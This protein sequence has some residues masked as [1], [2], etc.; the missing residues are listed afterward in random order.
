MAEVGKE[1]EAHLVG[2][3]E[4]L[5]DQDSWMLVGQVSEED[6]YRLENLQVVGGSGRLVIPWPQLRKETSQLPPQGSRQDLEQCPVHH[7]SPCR[8]DIDPGTERQD[9]LA[10]VAAANQHP[11][12]YFGD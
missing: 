1:P 5:K 2:P 12:I 11:T 10:L 4:I 9:L 8:Q 3:V 6:L 7:L